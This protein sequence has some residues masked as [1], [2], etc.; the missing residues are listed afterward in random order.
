MNC[1]WFLIAL[2]ASFAQGPVS[3]FTSPSERHYERCERITIPMCMNM[4]YNMTK[5]PNL[6]GHINQKDAAI[7]VH[8]FL[9]LVELGCS[10]LLRFFLC[11]FYAPMCT[12][13]VNAA[14][15]VSACRSMCLEVKSKCEPVLKNLMFSWPVA[16]DCQQ[17]PENS[18]KKHLCMEAPNVTDDPDLQPETVNAE[19]WSI[20][21][22]FK[23][24]TT[25]STG[26]KL[27]FGPYGLGREPGSSIHSPCPDRFVYVDKLGGRN[28][29]CAP[30]CNIDVYFKQ[31]DKRFA[32]IWLLVWAA[33]CC[34]STTITVLTFAIDTSRFKYPE[35][36]II[37][38]SMCYAI[39]S[40]AYMIR[41]ITGPNSISCDRLRDGTEFLI[42]EGLESTWCIVVFLIL[43][44]FGMA[45]AIWWVIL[46]LT[47]FLAAGRKW[48]QE[49]IEALSSYFHVAAWAIPAVK[50][51][52][53]L[54]MRRVDGDELTGLCFVGNQDVVALTGFVLAPLI[55]YLLT[56]TLFIFAGFFAMF[57]IRRNLKQDGT[58][59]RKLEKLMAKIGI[60]SV[61]Y[62]VPA[63]C[64]IGCYLYERLN[65]DNWKT[66]AMRRRCRTSRSG[67]KDCA[68]SHS[69][70]T[71]EVYMLKIF[72]SL[73]V[74]ITSGMWIW[75]YKTIN[76]WKNFFHSRFSRRK[77]S[78]HGNYQQAPV[79][80]M[81][82]QGQ[83]VVPKNV[84]TRV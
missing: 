54:T 46:T 36:P 42:Q 48:V 74:G 10:K 7:Q 23:E 3:G 47:W 1:L 55:T 78:Y 51:I 58:N 41:G 28:Y 13:M 76:S 52:V 83:K 6:L 26:K 9:P 81:K 5:M 21:Q 32:E 53:I 39:Y 64:V 77:H 24:K 15:V 62:T 82:I 49:A 68:L 16:L 2:L 8:E 20:V 17:L 35:R 63:T 57:K 65:F 69:I 18:N 67:A 33:F 43:Y 11:S 44:Y 31:E 30:R 37:F 70:P 59:I 38:L 56:G 79:S 84:G 40:G 80:L 4:R 12:E 27:R 19:W 34:I 14:L 73:I 61:L 66:E 25:E 29:S 50:T 45:S 22:S 72:M 71:V 60:F 75:S